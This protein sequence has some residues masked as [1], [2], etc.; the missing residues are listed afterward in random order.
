[1]PALEI[2]FSR[3]AKQS[4]PAGAVRLAD[5]LGRPVPLDTS[6]IGSMVLALR[7]ARAL[8]SEAWYTLKAR[9]GAF[10]DLFGSNGRD[11]TVAISFQVV[12][13]DRFGSIEGTVVDESVSD[14]KGPLVVLAKPVESA[15][16]EI[17]R[18]TVPKPGPF[19][20]LEVPEGRYQLG[21]FRDRN[22]NGVFDPGVV[23]PNVPAERYKILPDTLRV[24]AR[25]PYEG[26]I[27]RLH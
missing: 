3:P 23:F 19:A 8:T 26:A 27:V 13:A 9:L 16:S 24:R 15:G 4:V 22:A 11:T 14:A 10:T 1:M 7:P 25:W 21:A 17:M 20:L 6:W 18:A 12:S 5:T 2:F